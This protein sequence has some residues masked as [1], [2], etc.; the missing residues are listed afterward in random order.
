[1]VSVGHG[2][3][4]PCVSSFPWEH[5]EGATL[6]YY[7]RGGKKEK[8][9]YSVALGA[10][11]QMWHVLHPLHTTGKNSS[12]RQR[13]WRCIILSV[14][15]K[16]DNKNIIWHRILK[17]ENLE[18]YLLRNEG[19][20]GL[21][22]NDQRDET[23]RMISMALVWHQLIKKCAL[24]QSAEYKNNNIQNRLRSRLDKDGNEFSLRKIYCDFKVEGLCR[25]SS[26]WDSSSYKFKTMDISFMIF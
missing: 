4:A 20:Q 13:Q 18:V 12:H 25:Y 1:M 17:E 6:Y 5:T 23:F 3:F 9:K 24:H 22:N 15:W 26:L 19:G 14:E 7:G 8:P 11:A 2:G 21:E 16:F 10:F